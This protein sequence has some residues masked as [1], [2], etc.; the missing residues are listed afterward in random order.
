MYPR[1]RCQTAWTVFEAKLRMLS[2]TV[3]VSPWFF[4][5]LVLHSSDSRLSLIVW[6]TLWLFLS[7]YCVIRQLITQIC[8]WRLYFKNV[9]FYLLMIVSFHADNMHG[10]V[11]KSFLDK[12]F[13]SLPVYGLALHAT[14]LS[15]TVVIPLNC[16]ITNKQLQCSESFSR[17]C[18]YELWYSSSMFTHND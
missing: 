7:S 8:S 3:I 10:P 17:L 13:R 16:N 14:D 5:S 12:D 1:W 9:S 11:A 2:K 18:V 4:E 15:T 6:A